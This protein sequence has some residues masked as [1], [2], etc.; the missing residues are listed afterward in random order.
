MNHYFK[1]HYSNESQRIRQKNNRR[2]KQD[3]DENITIEKT[4][5][6]S[7]ISNSKIEELK[8]KR[9][10]ILNKLQQ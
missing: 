7:S 1:N 10:N 5:V 4:I 9:Q 6:L 8:K 2:K 3:D